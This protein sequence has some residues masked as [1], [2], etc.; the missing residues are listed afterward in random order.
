MKNIVLVIFA[1]A[2]GFVLSEILVRVFYHVPVD[3]FAHNPVLQKQA[4][5]TTVFQ[6]DDT[7]GHRLKNGCFVGNYRTGFVCIADIKNDLKENDRL[8]VLNTGDSSTSGWDSNVVKENAKRKKS[9]Q[10]LLSPFHNYKT[11]SSFLAEDERF[12]VINAG[13]PGYSSFQGKIYLKQLLDDFKKAGIQIDVVTVYFGNNDSTWNNNETDEY[14]ISGSTFKIYLK[15]FVSKI[16]NIFKITTRV[17]LPEF[18]KNLDS[19]I[20]TCKQN[21][22]EVILIAP[23]IPKTWPPGLRAVGLMGEIVMFAYRSRKIKVGKQF[24][25]AR[26]YYD[27][28][29]VE[30]EKGNNI[31]AARYLIKAQQFDYVVPRIKK[32]YLEAIQEV[33]RENDVKLVSVESKIPVSD[34]RYFVDYCHPDEPA[35][36]LIAN[37]LISNLI[38]IKKIASVLVQ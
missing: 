5:D 28:G 3:N 33:A 31:D 15:H 4:S 30:L 24:I 6:P 18:R 37:G 35:N 32:G 12:Y 2:I 10:P 9:G 38:E 26:Q 23:V 7:L 21:N 11:Y 19:M 13:V 14:L 27:E 17:P 34:M 8:V 20:K 25:K 36:I 29:M 16:S 22:V 1:I